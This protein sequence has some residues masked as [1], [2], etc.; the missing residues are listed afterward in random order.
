MFRVSR[1]HQLTLFLVLAVFF[2]GSC[3]PV[4]PTSAVSVSPTW[5]SLPAVTQ[6]IEPTSSPTAVLTAAPAQLGVGSIITS[7]K[8]GMTPVYVPAGEFSMGNDSGWDEEKPIHTVE[9]DDFWIDQTE[10]TN[11]MYAKCVQEDSCA[12]PSNTAHFDDSNYANHPVVYVSWHDANQYCAWAGRRLPTE[13]E[14]EKAARGT[15]KRVFPWGDTIDCSLANYWGKENGCVDD[16]TPVGIYPDGVSPYGVLDMTG[17]ALEW[18][19]TL[20]ARYPYDASDGREDLDASGARVLRG[21]SWNVT[22]EFTRGS[23]R[24]WY[25][26]GIRRNYAGFRCAMSVGP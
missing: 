24:D 1:A 21:G 19:S 16:T 12:Q 15:D 26:P 2:L 18:V 8:D 13:A 7:E 9:L 6:T 10:V 4:P 5:T 23:R 22:A 20:F 14:W 3:S 17:N 11:A 25:L